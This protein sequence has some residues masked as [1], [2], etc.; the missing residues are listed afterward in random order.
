MEARSLKANERGKF[1]Y[2]KEENAIEKEKGY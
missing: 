1:Y 2:E